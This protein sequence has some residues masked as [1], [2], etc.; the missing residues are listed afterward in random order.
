MKKK[1]III[2]II[3]ALLVSCILATGGKRG[4]VML[5]KE[6][7]ISED[8]RKMTLYVGVASSMGYIRTYKAKQDSDTLYITFY[9]TF[10]LNS[11]IGAKDK[12]EIDVDPLCQY[13]YFYSG[14]QGYKLVLEKNAET[15]E[16][17]R[18][19]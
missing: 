1:L 14:N 12:F 3:I 10:G 6:C 11:S 8:G 15:N 7:S 4:D 13:V 18:G 19:Y 16:W 2:F 9:S 5:R 17:Q